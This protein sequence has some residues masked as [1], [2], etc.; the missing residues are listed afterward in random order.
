MFFKSSG[1]CKYAKRRKERKP[2]IDKKNKS[3]KEAYFTLVDPKAN[4]LSV[5]EYD[6]VDDLDKKM[7]V[8]YDF[9]FLIFAR[10]WRYM[11]KSGVTLLASHVQAIN[12]TS[13]P[14]VKDFI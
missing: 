3:T 14:E 7:K 9:R 10:L 2:S 11:G 13:R 12:K 1:V 4:A 6:S 8:Y 5:V